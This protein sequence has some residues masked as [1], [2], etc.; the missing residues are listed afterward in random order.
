MSRAIPWSVRPRS[1]RLPLAAAGA[2]LLPAVAAAGGAPQIVPLVVEGDSVPG[3]GLVTLI[4]NIAVNG[5]GDW[6][7]EADT[8]AATDFDVVLLRNGV[9]ELREGD[10]VAAFPA[11]ATLG[12]FDSVTLNDSGQ[13]GFNFF[14]DGPPTS[15]DSSVNAYLDTSGSV[16]AEMV[17]VI[18]ESEEVPDLSPGTPLLGIFDVKINDPGQLLVTASVDDPAIPTTVDRAL[19]VWTTDPDTGGI[20]SSTLIAAEGDVLPGQ[21]VALSDFGTGPHETAINAA[22]AVM[23]AVDIPGGFDA[24]Y[25]WDSGTFTEIA[26]EG[27]ASPVAGRNWSS[28][29]STALDV[30]GANHAFRGILDGD[31]ATDSTLILNGAAFIQEG[32]TLPAIGGSFTFT[33]F[34]TGPLEVSDSGDLLWF[35]DWNDPNTAIDAGLFLNDQLLVQE[36]VTTVG[37]L[38]V[39]ATLRG[40][41]DG[42]HMNDDGSLIIF[43][44]VLASGLDGAFLIQTDR[45]FAD[46]FESGDTSSWT[47]AIGEAP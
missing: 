11:G 27:D 23:F 41:E 3:V 9:L 34:G 42:Y 12:S 4:N 7:V 22:G 2:L 13:S 24:I 40:V 5:H 45:I 16:A 19:Y 31:T 44:A 47:L 33:S 18:Q 36:G 46:G 26:Q 32:D 28:L 1:L 35:G 29:T 17:E 15:E 25:G 30:N 10:A 6:L 39:I 8:D 43:E 20:A 21:A 14:L 38:G 37:G